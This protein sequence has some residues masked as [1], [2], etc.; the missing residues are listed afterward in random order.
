MSKDVEVSYARGCAN[1][2]CN[3]ETFIFKALEAAKNADATIIVAG[4]DLSIEAEG[5]DRTDLLLPGYQTQLIN[6]VASIA[7][8]PVI[9]VIFSGSAVDISF[10]KNNRKIKS[11]IWAGYPGGEGGTAIA[12]VIFGRYNPGA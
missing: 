6:R 5:K 7:K 1:V 4:L 2:Q 8:S 10:A 11:I 9:L 12:D 3:N